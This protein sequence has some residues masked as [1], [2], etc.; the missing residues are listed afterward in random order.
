[1]PSR[2]R[3]IL[4]AAALLL[5]L[6]LA[7]CNTT[8]PAAPRCA[9]WV[10]VYTGEPVTYDALVDD[11]ADS[12]VIYIGERHTVDRHHDIQAEIVRRLIARDVPLV[13]GLEMIEQQY[14]EDVDRYNRGEITFDE[15]ATAIQWEQN[16]SNYEDYRPIIESAHAAGAPLLA[17][18][19]PRTAVRAVARQGLDNLAEDV[20]AKLPAD[21]DLSD[22]M[23]LEHMKQVMMVHAHVNEMMLRAMY[24]AQVVRDETMA[25]R[26]AA[27]LQSPAGANRTAVVLC[28]AGHVQQRMGIPNRV[29]RRMPGV[30]DRIIVLSESGDVVLSERQMA[31]AREIEITHEQQRVLDRPIADYLHVIGPRPAD[32][33]TAAAP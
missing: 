25:D 15:L 28:G 31:M 6:T 12:R 16:W 19:A 13:L 8:R 22:Q 10:D 5:P 1:M 23:Y 4:T 24:A 33:S 26:L 32:E 17:L 9:L 2:S 11:L 27:F 14:Q 7:A 30:R 21:I 18:N 20:R 3:T 29:R